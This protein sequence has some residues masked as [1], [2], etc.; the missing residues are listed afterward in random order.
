VTSIKSLDSR[1]VSTT[2]KEDR[3]LIEDLLDQMPCV[4]A[5]E[6]DVSLGPARPRP[7]GTRPRTGTKKVLA[8]EMDEAGSRRI[9]LRQMVGLQDLSD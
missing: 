4:E 3:K 5:G 2:S 8:A 9:Q 7:Q 1:P 6:A